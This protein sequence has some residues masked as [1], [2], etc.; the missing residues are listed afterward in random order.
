MK[1]KT[2]YANGQKIFDQSDDLLTY[3]F[4][5][6]KVKAHGKSIDDV[7]IGEW[8]FF[9]ESGD[10]W[11][12]GHFSGGIKHGPWVRYDRNGELEYDE[13]FENGKLMKRT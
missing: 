2:H 4:K 5:D 11:Q 9:R 8:R 1:D 3:Y 6:G 13:T 10:L 7:M 12:V